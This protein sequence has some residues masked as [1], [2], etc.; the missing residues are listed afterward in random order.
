MQKQVGQQLAVEITNHS[1]LPKV[2]GLEALR[3]A[4]PKRVLTLVL[5]SLLACAAYGDEHKK[6]WYPIGLSGAA[7]LPTGTFTLPSVFSFTKMSNA[8]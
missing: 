8:S 3:Y 5:R 7:F 2:F 6:S 4:L 1:D